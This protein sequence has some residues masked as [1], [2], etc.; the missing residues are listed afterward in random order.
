MG[1]LRKLELKLRQKFITTRVKPK[2]ITKDGALIVKADELSGSLA[3]L[4]KFAKNRK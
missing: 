1:L 2:A 3:L 4:A